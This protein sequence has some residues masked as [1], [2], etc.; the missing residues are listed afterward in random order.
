MWHGCS[1]Q[2]PG[3]GPAREGNKTFGWGPMAA[4]LG[5]AASGLMPLYL[6]VLSYEAVR[7]RTAAPRIA[8]GP[9]TCE[10]MGFTKETQ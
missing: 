4:R 6:P 9:R 10:T 2:Y 3:G 5:R 1:S 7:H 8:T